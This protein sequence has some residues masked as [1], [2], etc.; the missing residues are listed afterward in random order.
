MLTLI[1]GLT[2]PVRGEL[3]VLG[4]DMRTHRGRAGIR[5]RVGLV[6]PPGRPGGF[7]VRGLVTHSAWLLR[8]PA[9][10]CRT[11]VARAIDRLNLAGWACCQVKAVPEDVSRRAWLAA[12]TVH[13]PDLLLV[14]SLLDGIADE[15]AATLAGY[16]RSLSSGAAVLVAGCDAERL[17]LCCARRLTLTDGIADDG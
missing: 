9:P 7:T 16:L 3:K 4:E 2:V 6:P 17:A 5:Y 8:L 12:C 1:A 11:R 13:E 15:D 10:E 14:D